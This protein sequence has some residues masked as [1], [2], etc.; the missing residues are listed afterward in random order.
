MKYPQRM[1]A[2]IAGLLLA[3]SGSI[4]HAQDVVLPFNDGSITN[5]MWQW[6]GGAVA[7]WEWDGTKDANNNPAS[8]ALKISVPMTG[9]GDNQ[10][11]VGM[12]LSG[13]GAYD[14]SVQINP[15]NYTNL[16]FDVLWD[17]NSTFDI[18]T[19][20]GTAGDPDG[21]GLG[22]VAVQYG[23]TWIPDPMN[24]VLTN[25]GNWQHFVIPLNPSWAVAPGLIFKKYFN[26]GA[27]FSGTVTYWID[28]IKFV[29]NTNV[30]VPDPTLA[31][32]SA[33][34]GLSITTAVPASQFQRQSIRSVPSDTVQWVGNPNTLTYEL[35]IADFPGAGYEGFQAHIFLVPDTAG[36]TAPDYADPNAIYVDIR[37][38]ADGSGEGTFR[39]KTNQ[40]NGNSQ[41]FTAGQGVLGPL[42]TPT[43]VGTWSVSFSSDTNITLSGPGGGS[44]NVVM[45][46]EAAPFFL[47]STPS[48]GT[49]FGVQPNQVANIGQSAVF[50]RIRILNGV[51]TVVDD[52]FTTVDPTQE[53]DP[54]L[55][56]L[57]ID[58][59]NTANSL[60]IVDTLP[61]YWLSWNKPDPYLSGV[62][63]KPS[64]TAPGTDLNL[65][66]R[67]A[68]GGRRVFVENSNVVDT[69]FYSLFSTN[70]P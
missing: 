46:P 34:K 22:L 13:V 7:A 9:T 39:W 23:Q 18:A 43:V 56:I 35:T 59:G 44:T 6:W 14:T 67:E 45:P 65:P 38:L 2:A 70:A 16:E 42:I 12:A 1:F 51:T 50:S 25:E 11:S 52:Q 33:K 57:R 29:F 60:K 41:M 49:Y 10:Y 54:L 8:G 37:K 5:G 68:G 20:M 63:I 21:L 53:V 48:M 58:G 30:V 66:I 69:A 27:Q 15:V 32:K 47:S 26:G 61:A 31:I 62:F 55:W 28:N 40:A 36:G 64:L 3:V 17:T 4:S 24:P 19:F